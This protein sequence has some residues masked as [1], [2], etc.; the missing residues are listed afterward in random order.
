[1]FSSKD[2]LSFSGTAVYL[3]T[4]CIEFWYHLERL[5]ERYA[6]LCASSCTLLIC[7]HDFIQD[8]L[9][10]FAGMLSRIRSVSTWAFYIRF[11]CLSSVNPE[12]SRPFLA[13]ECMVNTDSVDLSLFIWCLDFQTSIFVAIY[14]S[15]PQMYCIVAVTC[16]INAFITLA[17]LLSDRISIKWE[18]HLFIIFS[19]A[20][21]VDNCNGG[22]A[23]RPERCAPV[24]NEFNFMNGSYL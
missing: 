4:N 16:V 18:L 9:P 24:G 19:C 13:F 3:V 15:I 1:M 12:L 23:K 6:I 8:T 10:L 20:F 11:Y 7:C 21:N 2:R 22:Y 17:D 14:L 5:Y